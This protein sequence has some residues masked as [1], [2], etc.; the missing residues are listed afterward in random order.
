MNYELKEKGTV[1]S[2]YTA[3]TLNAII[4]ESDI[5]CSVE[6]YKLQQKIV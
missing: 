6:N 3:P 4:S 2:D 5:F 1:E